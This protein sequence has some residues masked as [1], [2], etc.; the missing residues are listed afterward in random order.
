MAHDAPE[1]EDEAGGVLGGVVDEREHRGRAAHIA[2][3][4]GD[5]AADREPGPGRDDLREAT[6]R[7]VAPDVDGLA[8][9]QRAGDDRELRFARG[10]R[11]RHIVVTD[12]RISVQGLRASML[13]RPAFCAH[14]TARF[15]IQS[16]DPYYPES[17]Q[18]LDGSP[19]VEIKPFE[20][21]DL[22]EPPARGAVR[23]VQ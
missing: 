12:E 16:F 1:G 14:E 23:R 19:F 10:T 4:A 18:W 17:P 15:S 6:G 21:G 13:R 9:H 3:I 11:V 5:P 2:A 22:A 8:A 20:L 7:A